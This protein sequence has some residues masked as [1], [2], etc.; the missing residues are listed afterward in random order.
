MHRH[1]AVDVFEAVMVD[2]VVRAV[3]GLFGGLEKEFYSAFELVSF[4]SE[5]LRRTK[6]HRGMAVVAA[7]VH[8]AFV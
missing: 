6:E 2:I 5:E 4:A 1:R 7:G 3:T 8:H